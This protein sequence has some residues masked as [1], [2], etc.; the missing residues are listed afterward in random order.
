MSFGWNNILCLTIK[1]I[2]IKKKKIFQRPPNSTSS[3]TQHTFI[4][5]TYWKLCI[6]QCLGVGEKDG[7]SSCAKGTYMLP[8]E[9]KY[10]GVVPISK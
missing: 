1:G 4:E 3:S 2:Y 10:Q 9:D 8:E 7:Q 5:Y 6:I